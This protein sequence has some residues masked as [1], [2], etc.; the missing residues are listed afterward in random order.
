[1]NTQ[2]WN[3]REYAKAAAQ[4]NMSS[5]LGRACI[6]N[7]V[8]EREKEIPSRLNTLN[9]EL[10]MLQDTIDQFISRLQP[11]IAPR[12]VNPTTKKDGVGAST[13]IGGAI[14]EATE[15]LRSFTNRLNG[16]MS[17]LEI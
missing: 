11:V 14:F 12:P 8:A 4:Q 15:R 9:Y 17:E 7:A 1:M 13:S 6:G 10:N 16:V 3:E 5:G 2:E